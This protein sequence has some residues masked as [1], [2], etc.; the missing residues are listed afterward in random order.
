MTDYEAWIENKIEDAQDMQYEISIHRCP[1]CNSIMK[2]MEEKYDLNIPF[3]DV[4]WECT[5]TM[6]EYKEDI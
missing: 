5:N 1:K 3:A 4:W 6:C 2:K